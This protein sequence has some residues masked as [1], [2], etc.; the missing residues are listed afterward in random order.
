MDNRCNYIGLPLIAALL[1]LRNQ[2]RLNDP[3]FRLR[4]G[5]LYRGYAKGREWWEIT[6]ALR[7]VAAVSIGTFGSLIGIPEVQVGL[8]LFVV[9]N[10]FL[11]LFFYFFASFKA[12]LFASV[13]YFLSSEIDRHDNKNSNTDMAQLYFKQ[14]DSSQNISDCCRH[15]LSTSRTSM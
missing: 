15:I 8:A 13:F 3:D 6:V 7:K 11:T 9:K 14:T 2:N 4:Y 5:L 1:I 10:I 12:K